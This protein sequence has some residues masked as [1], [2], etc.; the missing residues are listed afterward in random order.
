ML[1]CK[2]SWSGRKNFRI[3]S[4]ISLK[5]L[6]LKILIY[7]KIHSYYYYIKD[8]IK[9]GYLSTHWTS[10][11]TKWGF[12][13]SNLFLA[14]DFMMCLTLQLLFLTE[15]GNSE[16]ICIICTSWHA[17]QLLFLWILSNK[18]IFPLYHFH[19]LFLTF[20]FYITLCF[21]K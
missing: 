4:S 8:N 18:Y 16:W 21:Y 17:M 5:V 10:C 2:T 1:L 11:F 7:T 12:L 19:R 14:S 20:M 6:L 15:K 13:K 9:I 3:I